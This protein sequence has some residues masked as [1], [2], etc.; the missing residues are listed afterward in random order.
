MVLNFQ[1]Y[2]GTLTIRGVQ[3]FYTNLNTNQINQ[4]NY[5]YFDTQFPAPLL[6]RLCSYLKLYNNYDTT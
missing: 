6:T 1:H 4:L 3:M 5:F 2:H